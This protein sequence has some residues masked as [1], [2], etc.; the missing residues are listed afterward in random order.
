MNLP[1]PPVNKIPVGIS[2]CVLGDPVRYN[3]GH[4][5]CRVCTE[6]LGDYF[7]YVPFCPEVA[8]GLGVPR[9][10]IQL[11]VRDGELRALG[12][13]DPGLDVTQQLLDYADQLAPQVSALR[14]FIFMQK[15]PSCGLDSTPR[16]LPH[17][18]VPL[19]F[20]AGLFAER[21]RER[22]ADLP[23]EEAGRLENSDIRARFL[24]QVLARD[25]RL[26]GR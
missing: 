17:N 22:F 9:A 1:I 15:S 2:Q 26:R 21:L 12:V 14:G 8:I 23:V 6:L 3:G 7:D 11:V 20:G 25:A 18:P 19:A 24:A 10:P 4:K 5:L 16:Y 13:E